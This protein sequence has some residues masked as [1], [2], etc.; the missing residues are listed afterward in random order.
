MLVEAL[1][2]LRSST[3]FM[4]RIPPYVVTFSSLYSISYRGLNIPATF[5]LTH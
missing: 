5:S 3:P 4:N 1:T 2:P